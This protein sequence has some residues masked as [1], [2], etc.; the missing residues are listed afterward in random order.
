MPD[1][2]NCGSGHM[3]GNITGNYQ[4]GGG[5]PP[6]YIGREG[7][8]C[9]EDA[10]FL[11]CWQSHIPRLK[12]TSTCW[13]RHLSRLKNTSTCWYRHLPTLKNTST[14]WYRHIP[15]LKNSSTCWYRHLSRLKRQLLKLWLGNGAVETGINGVCVGRGGG[16]LGWEEWG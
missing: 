11:K 7:Y 8:K 16:E 4:H 3:L 14:C 2:L 15:R 10:V 9:T 6:I 12:N 5:W 1:I 13:Y